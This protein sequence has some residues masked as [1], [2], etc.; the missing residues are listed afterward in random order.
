MDSSAIIAS[1]GTQWPR[2]APSP[3]R[4]I[5]A[6]TEMPAAFGATERKATKGRRAPWY[7][8]GT[9]MWKGTMPIL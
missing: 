8:S 9:H 2:C 1:G 3:K 5:D 7:V 4:K 6:S